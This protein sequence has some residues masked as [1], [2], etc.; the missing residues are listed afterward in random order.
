[1]KLST[2]GKN[3]SKAEVLDVTRHGLWLFVDDHEYLLPF[4]E[5]PWFKEARI[6]EIYNVKFMNG[7]HLYWPDLDIDLDLDSLKN[8][9]KYP[10]IYR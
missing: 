9:E 1:M 10:L 5:Y 8:P 7:I 6:S 4:H 3:T 2:A